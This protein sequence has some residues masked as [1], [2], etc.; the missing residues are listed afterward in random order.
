[1]AKAKALSAPK[2]ATAKAAAAKASKTVVK[3]GNL[4]QPPP[5]PEKVKVGSLNKGQF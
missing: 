3:K 2:K 1:M 5:A 4:L